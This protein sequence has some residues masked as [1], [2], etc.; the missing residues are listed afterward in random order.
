ML[1]RSV[2]IRYWL[3][4]VLVAI[5]LVLQVFSP[6]RA[7]LFV[8]VALSGALLLS[9]LWAVTLSRRVSVQRLRRYGWA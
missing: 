4:L 3:P 1:E 7:I 2:R 5:L 8:L 6:A 9:Y